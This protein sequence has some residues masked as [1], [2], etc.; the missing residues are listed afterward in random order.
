MASGGTTPPKEPSS[1]HPMAYTGAIPKRRESIGTPAKSPVRLPQ[2][3]PQRTPIT[4]ATPGIEATAFFG[5]TPSTPKEQRYRVEKGGA[6]R[7]SPSSAAKKKPVQVGELKTYQKDIPLNRPFLNNYHKQKFRESG[8]TFGKMLGRGGWG[9]VFEAYFD[10][11]FVDESN[12][13][14]NCH[15]KLA[16]K[17][18]DLE[19]WKVKRNHY[20]I[21]LEYLTTEL[22]AMEG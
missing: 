22:M 10:Y 15:H 8:I 16:C 4:P 3:S 14:H 17:R 7:A 6:L 20:K 1:P 5:G 11:G 18:L 13:N 2:R 19:R 12:I 9:S 21:G